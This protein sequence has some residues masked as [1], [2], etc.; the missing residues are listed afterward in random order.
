MSNIS[1]ERLIVAAVKGDSEALEKLKERVIFG[2]Y[3]I[4]TTLKKMQCPDSAIKGM[5][6]QIIRYVFNNLYDYRFIAPFHTHAYRLAVNRALQYKRNNGRQQ[7]DKERLHEKL[8]P[9]ALSTL[10]NAALEPKHPPLEQI[11]FEIRSL[12]SLLNKSCDIKTAGS[13]CSGHPNREE[14]QLGSWNPYGG[15]IGLRPIG[16]PCKTLDFLIGL[17]ARLDNKHTLP[18]DTIAIRER[19]KHVGAETLFHSGAPIVLVRVSFHFFV[20]HCEESCR[21]EIWEQFIDS[22]GALIPD[23]AERSTDVDTPEK[24]AQLLQQV[25]QRLPFLFSAKLLT[26]REGYPGIVLNT[27]ADLAVCQWFSRLVF[28]QLHERLSKAGYVGA[29]DAAGNTPFA[30][31]WVFGLRPFLNQELI[32]LS[33]LLTPRWEPRTREDHLNI[34]KLLELAATEQLYA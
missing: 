1:D 18:D 19:Y 13:S 6:S 15:Y 28:V 25:L 34:W 33:H 32:P 24:A 26:S 23:A 10:S 27:M 3:G 22:L 20:C 21:L 5:E 31:K 9:P 30:E 8:A 29:S 17:L 16:S 7:P 14:W 12:V 11:D 4:R 2:K